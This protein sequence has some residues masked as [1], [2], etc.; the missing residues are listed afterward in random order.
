MINVDQ[1]VDYGYVFGG[2]VIIKQF[3][4]KDFVGF[5]IFGYCVDVEVGKVLFVQ[6]LWFV[7]VGEDFVFVVED[8][9]EKVVL[10]IFVLEWFFIVFF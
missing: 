8:G 7:V 3:V 6:M 9:F 2:S 10:D 1:E 4:L 5:V